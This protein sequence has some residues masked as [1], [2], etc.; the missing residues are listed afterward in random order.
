MSWARWVA[1]VGHIVTLRSRRGP[2]QLGERTAGSSREWL[3]AESCLP[4][5][6]RGPRRGAMLKP[7]DTLAFDPLGEILFSSLGIRLGDVGVDHVC[8][9]SHIR[10]VAEVLPAHRRKLVDVA[11]SPN[12]EASEVPQRHPEISADQEVRANHSVGGRCNS[13]DRPID[14]RCRDAQRGFDS[15]PGEVWVSARSR[16]GGEGSCVR[17]R[18]RGVCL[19]AERMR[20]CATRRPTRCGADARI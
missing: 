14:A 9:P 19:P 13:W 5:A 4:P 1:F 12:R 8:S 10:F 18:H 17:Q 20:I 2:H 3:T 11:P 7:G 6:G 16:R 15:R